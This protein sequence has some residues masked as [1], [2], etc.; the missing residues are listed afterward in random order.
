MADYQALFDNHRRLKQL[1]HELEELS[2]AIVD[3]DPR[4][5]Q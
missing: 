1:L 4:W 5:H 3:R 2:L